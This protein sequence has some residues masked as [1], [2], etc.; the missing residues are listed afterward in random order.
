MKKVVSV[1]IVLCVVMSMVAVPTYSC[2]TVPEGMA[3]EDVVQ[4]VR[5]WK[6]GIIPFTDDELITGKSGSS[7]I[8]RAACSHFAMAYALVKMGYLNPF[9]GDTPV[10]HIENAREHNAFRTEWGYYAFEDSAKL[11]EGITYVGVEYISYMSRDEG[12]EYVKGLM[13]QGYY[14]IGIISTPDTGGHCIFFDGINEDGTVSIGDS[15]FNGITWEEYYG[16]VDTQW[17]YL[18]V[19]KCEDKPLLEQ[20]SIYDI[21]ELEPVE[22]VRPMNSVEIRNRIY[23]LLPIFT[24]EDGIISLS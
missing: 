10:T 12:L 8:R 1:L 4:D 20:P 17:S 9:E 3:E 15:W 14:V 21:P 23:R 18:E 5:Y 22:V 11:Y 24:M 6:Q 19:L 7:T 16:T 13:E 2:Y